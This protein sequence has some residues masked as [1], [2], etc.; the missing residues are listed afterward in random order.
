MLNLKKLF[1][2]NFIIIFSLFRMEDKRYYKNINFIF[3]RYWEKKAEQKLKV[4][5]Q[6]Q[7]EN[8]HRMMQLLIFLLEQI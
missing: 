6:Q 2:N 3:I 5:K 8:Y 7:K 1:I 4:F